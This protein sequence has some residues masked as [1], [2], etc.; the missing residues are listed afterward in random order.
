M[1]ATAQSQAAAGPYGGSSAAI[2]PTAASTNNGS[3]PSGR[4]G[5][6]HGLPVI[7]FDEE[8]LFDDDDEDEADEDSQN[9]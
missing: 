3:E 5:D 6:A 7:V 8:S 1:A 9:T 2:E 4:A